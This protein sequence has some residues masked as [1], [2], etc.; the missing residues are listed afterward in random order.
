M[1]CVYELFCVEY[2]PEYDTFAF[3]EQCDESLHALI[4]ASRADLRRH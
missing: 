4:L 1:S 3:E 2:E